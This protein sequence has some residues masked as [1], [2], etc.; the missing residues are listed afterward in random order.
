MQTTKEEETITQYRKEI[1][2]LKIN[3]F[4]LETSL[5]EASTAE[6]ILKQ[7]L[8]EAK[9]RESLLMQKVCFYYVSCS[10]F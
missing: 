1:E 7:N 5:T 9:A 10:Y 3:V 6:L 4:K 8:K 2:Q